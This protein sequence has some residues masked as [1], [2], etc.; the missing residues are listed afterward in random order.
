MKSFHI[1][2]KDGSNPYYHFACPIEEHMK[3]LKR[4]KRNYTLKLVAVVD[5]IEFYEAEAKHGN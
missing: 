2:F 3:A 5:S 4:W 1:D